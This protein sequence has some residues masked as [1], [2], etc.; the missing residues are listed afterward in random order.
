[1]DE[2]QASIALEDNYEEKVNRHCCCGC[3]CDK[4]Q[5]IMR[6]QQQQGEI[7]E[8]CWFKKKA[9]K[10]RQ[11]LEWNNFIGRFCIHGI[12]NKKKNKSRMQFHY[13]PQS[14]ALNFDDGYYNNRE[15]DDPPLGDFAARFTAPHQTIDDIA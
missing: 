1:M 5:W 9:E 11:I 10:L 7:N 13:D 15:L 8:G 12:C 4:S 14:Y 6:Q 2:K 3:L